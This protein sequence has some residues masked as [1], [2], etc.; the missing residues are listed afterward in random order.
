MR[1]LRLSVGI[2]TV[3]AAAAFG[4]ILT[5]SLHVTSPISAAKTP[6]P[7]ASPAAPAAPSAVGKTLALPSFSD[8]A[9]NVL[10]SVVSITSREV[11]R[12]SG[13]G[14]SP[15]GQGDPFEF[16][17][18]PPRRGQPQERS[19]TAGGS[20]FIVSSDG[21][22]L[23]NNHV[24]S[25]A[26]RIQVKLRDGEVFTA[27]V[28]GTD[29]ATDVALIKVDAKHNLP[30][31]NLGDSQQLRVG[32]WVMAVGN[33]LNF[34]GTV[35]VGVI[36]GKGRA[37]LS[38]DAN[39]RT[40]ENFLQ[41]DAAINF[42]NS[43]GPLVNAAGQVVGINTAMIQPAQNIGFAVPINTARAILPQLK[44]KGKVTR[45]ML[46]VRIGN[47]DQ[48]HMQAFHLPSMNG[49]FVEAVEPSGPA[50]KAGIEHGD[51]IVRVDDVEVKETRDLID[52]VS[53]KAPGTRVKLTVLR[54]GKT[55]T[56]SAALT[57][58]EASPS[59]ETERAGARGSAQ[60]R[61]GIAATELTSAI[62]QELGIPSGVSGIVIES[63]NAVSPAAEAGLAE[64]DV[65]TEINGVRVASVSQ[66]RS[67]IDKV[68]KGDYIRLYVRRFTPQEISRYVV[69]KP[70]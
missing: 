25:G 3:A 11:V 33:P 68:R 17:F 67:E 51:T 23:T 15:F 10:N 18:G 47:V 63:V 59:E 37:G 57:E 13:R 27:R 43:G 35:T 31:L 40:F 44:S 7:V 28:L 52:Y 49:A 29:P 55:R 14:N 32:D 60:G 34:E 62:R 65:I 20:G 38:G 8:V 36:S 9:D 53:S 22:I 48:D 4:M 58:R 64:G 45:S 24:V 12:T 39:T 5:G 66:F 26:Q 70:E 50:A 61:L 21:E 30:A 69:I 41:T 16:F 46:G 42:G 19:Q 56:L 54:D 1:S 6:A 2:A